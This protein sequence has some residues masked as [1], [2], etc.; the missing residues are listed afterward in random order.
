MEEQ[1]AI[2]VSYF[3]MAVIVVITLI[4]SGFTGCR[5]EY[6]QNGDVKSEGFHLGTTGK[7][8]YGVIV[9]EVSDKEE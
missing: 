6:Y 1:D 8:T 4:L 9:V 3:S 2:R 5:T 7:G